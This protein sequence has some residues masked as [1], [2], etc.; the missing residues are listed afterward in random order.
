MALIAQRKSFYHINQCSSKTLLKLLTTSQQEN[1]CRAFHDL[2]KNVR[3]KY[4][5]YL[6]SA[7]I[8]SQVFQN[9]SL[10][11][12]RREHFSSCNTLRNR[13]VQDKVTNLGYLNFGGTRQFN[14]RDVL[15]KEKLLSD[16]ALACR[17][18]NENGYLSW[19]RNSYLLTGV[20]VGMLSHGTNH[21]TDLAG[22]V[23]FL[24]AGLNISWGSIVYIY[25]LMAHRKRVQMSLPIT[26]L[27]V[28]GV[29]LNFCLFISVLLVFAA[30]CDPSLMT[31]RKLAVLEVKQ[32][33]D[34]SYDL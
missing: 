8:H 10:Y 28:A 15:E 9:C 12:S 1:Q 5:S 33:E 14:T 16:S 3:T 27:T 26:A 13:I 4:V 18:A 2:T 34:S 24:T 22:Y 29:L 19:C 30:D 31:H 25:N 17:L 6:P 11:V 7:S 21:F 23:T 32:Q 20:A